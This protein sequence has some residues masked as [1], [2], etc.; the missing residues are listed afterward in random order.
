MV[1]S[2]GG[3]WQRAARWVREDIRSAG[4]QLSALRSRTPVP[5]LYPYRFVTPLGRVR[6]HLR[7]HADRSALLF[8]NAVEALHLPP[9]GAEMVKYC[10]DQLPRPV[11]LARLREAY[12]RV[13]VEELQREL[14]RWAA[15]V[16]RLREPSE[17]HCS[18]CALGLAQ[19]PP[20]SVR[21]AAP[22]KADLALTYGCNN[23]CRHCY[24]EP[25]RTGH[26]ELPTRAWQEVLERLRAIGVP[27][28]IFTGGEP[29]LREDLPELVAHAE[30]LGLVCGVNTNG[31]RLADAALCRALADAGLDHVQVTL[32]STRPEV[33]DRLSGA[34]AWHESVEGLR[35]AKA[36]G[37]HVLTNTTLLREN[38]GEAAELPDFL[39]RLGVSTFAMNGLI[40]SGCGAH[41]QGHVPEELLLPLLG[42]MRARAAELGLRFLWYTPTRYCELDPVALGLGIKSC[43]AAEYSVCVEPNGDVLP[44]QSYY[45]AAGNLLTDSWE[46][47][48]ESELFHRLRHRR[49]EPERAGLPAECGECDQLGL[50]GG[51]CLLLTPSRLEVS[52]RSCPAA[53]Q[54]G[55]AGERTRVG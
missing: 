27:Y 25:G 35:Q 11:A 3:L 18:V 30:S 4:V 2:A 43:N 20:F 37:L 16:A 17:E 38:V 22:Y 41:H 21:A 6:L 9:S 34:A 1:K 53:V 26:G 52:S 51:G 49:E 45:Q 40:H 44:C 13:P 5:G 42:R 31:R 33:H 7:V 36:A 32:N 12:P 46:S 50:C 8:V 15:A 14:D 29:T 39:H 19:P 47:I 10:L 54:G 48:W 24:N 23:A 28:V 55:A